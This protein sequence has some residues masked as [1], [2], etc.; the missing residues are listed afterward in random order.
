MMFAVHCTWVTSNAYSSPSI[1]LASYSHDGWD[2]IH[3]D[4]LP[5]ELSILENLDAK[6]LSLVGFEVFTA[7]VLKIIFF[8][9]MTPCSA[10]CFAELF[11]HPEDGGDT[12]LRNVGYH[13]THYTASYPRRRYSSCLLLNLSRSSHSVSVRHFARSLATLFN[14]LLSLQVP[15]LTSVFH[16]LCF[17]K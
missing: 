9:D 15:Y 3:S 13:S 16:C 17:T 6:F 8:W 11:Y 12:F 5:C 14:K 10:R 7:V 2:N 4:T 1:V